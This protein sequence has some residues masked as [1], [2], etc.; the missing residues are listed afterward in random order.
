MPR[1][2]T[3]TVEFRGN[4]PRW[5]ARITV[6][7]EDGRIHRPWVDLERPDLKDDRPDGPDYKTAKKIARKRA[8]LAVRAPFVGAERATTPSATLVELED[9]W[10]PL[11]E[12]NPDLK[13]K[14][15][16]RYKQSWSHLVETFGKLPIRDITPVRLRE[17]IWRRRGDRSTSTV[18]NDCNALSRFF[19]DAIGEKWVAGPNPMRDQLVVDAKPKQTHQESE[20]IT[21]YT[22]DQLEALLAAEGMPDDVFGLLLLDAT[23]GA[24]DGELRGLQFKHTRDP[25]GGKACV[26]IVQQAIDTDELG[27]PKWG[28]KRMLPQH[29]QA[30]PW[31]SWWRAEGWEWMVGREPT[32][33]DFV[34]PDAGGSMVRPQDAKVVQKWAAV[35]K[36]P[37]AFTRADGSEDA[38]D[39]QAIRRTFASMLG[40]LEVDG[41]VLDSLLGHGVKTVRGR[42]Y[43]AIP[44][45]RKARAV[46]RLRLALPDRPGVVPCPPESSRE[47]SPD[48]QTPANDVA[49]PT[50]QPTGTTGDSGERRRATSWRGPRSSKPV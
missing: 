14:T 1:S 39:M 29:P 24:R 2:A 11:L 50:L 5:W 10:F 17:W 7:D 9:K 20:D 25:R 43:M 8:K 41:E 38:F 45:E 31:L 47:S 15:V 30:A 22:Q 49:T 12:R 48:P 37:A 23:T 26:N 44:F 32:D 18:L 19:Q 27:D 40:D 36:L 35:A 16:A 46:E 4:P 28:S 42:H 33:E 21:R 13:T 3:G 6:K 34:F